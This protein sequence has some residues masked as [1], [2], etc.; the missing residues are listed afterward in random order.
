MQD[1]IRDIKNDI[2]YLK[3]N[4]HEKTQELLKNR[5][6]KISIDKNG[7]TK[8]I[9]KMKNTKMQE[10]REK[11]EK[12]AKAEIEEMQE[13]EQFI[14]EKSIRNSEILAEINEIYSY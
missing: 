9:K 14:I 8:G 3:Y 7:K 12:Q 4:N 10:I 2:E 6:T 11:Q 5:T 13:I 1:T